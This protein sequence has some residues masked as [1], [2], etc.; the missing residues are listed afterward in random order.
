MRQRISDN[1][2]DVQDYESDTSEQEPSVDNSNQDIE[3]DSSNENVAE[4]VPTSNP[5]CVTK[6]LTFSE[7]MSSSHPDKEPSEKQIPILVTTELSLENLDVMDKSGDLVEE[8][9]QE[10]KA[11]EDIDENEPDIV[12]STKTRTPPNTLQ[13]APS[14]SQSL[15]LPAPARTRTPDSLALPRAPPRRKK[16]GD[17]TSGEVCTMCYDLY[18]T[19]VSY[20][21]HYKL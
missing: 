14:P 15:E 13:S 7:N 17:R 3:S 2:T 18:V 16:R 5:D 20:T 4:N 1:T 9:I 11:C 21:Y 8:V 6:R 19:V 10:T 12:R